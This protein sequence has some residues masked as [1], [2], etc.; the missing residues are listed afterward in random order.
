MESDLT[1]PNTS[2]AESVHEREERLNLALQ[3]AGVGTWSWNCETN[4]MLWDDL[5]QRLLGLDTR[6]T[7][8]KLED[9]L[10]CVHKD[11]RDRVRSEMSNTQEHDGELNSEYRVVWKTD[12]SVHNLRWKG[13]IYRDENTQALRM[14]GACWEITD[15]K[16]IEAELAHEQHLLTVLLETMPEMIYFKDLESRFTRV[17]RAK[18]HNS[19]LHEPS[20]MLGKTDFDFFSDV[21]ARQAF[22]DE[23]EIMDTGIP[24]VNLEEKETW[25]DGHETWVST[26]KM[27]LRDPSG[28]IIGTFGLSRDITARKHAEEQLAKY[29]EELK[30]K[31]KEL[32][33]DLEMARELQNALLPQQYPSFPHSAAPKD[34]ALRFSHFFNPTAAVS[35]DFFDIL[36][37]S[38]TMA[39]MFICDVMG[40]GV[41]AALV[42]AI[43]RA[44]VEE[45]RATTGSP[46]EFL[47][48]LNR[49][50]LG[51][52]KQAQIPMFASAF[53]V[54]ADLA[55]G[56]LRY[57]NAGHPSPVYIQREADGGAKAHALNHCERGPVL[58]MFADAQYRTTC[59]PL[60]VDDRLLLF[61]DGLFEVEG[62]NGDFYDQ[63]RLLDAVKRRLSLPA[64]ELCREILS[65]IRQFSASKTFT[66]DVCIVTMQVDRL[67]LDGLT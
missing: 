65:E 2:T 10:E 62:E 56:E 30:R 67:A 26:T 61:T 52:L 5:M 42:A 60:S 33:E 14:T 34:S 12:A 8:G 58:G 18:L 57:A 39:G 51:V 23:Q 11:D 37:L 21:H 35:G 63:A 53:Y 31:N 47:S 32:E 49:A 45:Q 3:A 22:E 64:G 59:C 66:D 46:G 48:K 24:I 1:S 27:P 17:S 28:G 7:E 4:L 55:R 20:E 41:R 36:D 54:V 19:G 43:V 15:R 13:K 16:K 25:P 50:L 9:F 38:D 40:H 44:L 6:L 29:T